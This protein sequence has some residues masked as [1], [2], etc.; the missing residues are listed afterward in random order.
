MSAA[1]NAP[2]DICNLTLVM[3]KQDEIMS[4][5][6][7]KTDPE[8]ICA[9]WYDSV[10]KST[11][12]SHL[13][14]FSIKRV[15]LTPDTANPPLF[16]FSNAYRFPPDFLRYINRFD[17]LGNNLATSSFSQNED[18]EI[19]QNRILLNTETN[20]S[21]K[22]R[23]VFDN[24]SVATWDAL[25]VEL[26]AME[27]AIKIGRNFAATEARIRV[28]V[29]LRKELKAEARA[30]DGQERPPRRIERSRFRDAR[31]TRVATTADKFTRFR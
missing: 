17:D 13:F 28:L 6:D 31:R 2:I 5:D 8:K 14:N 10:R 26:M 24:I 23:Y 16:G 3:L 27:L 21:I 20:T 11:L 30:V 18:Y 9:R 29:E 15:L 25:F 12:R 7:P 1:P 4:I 19:E 22:I